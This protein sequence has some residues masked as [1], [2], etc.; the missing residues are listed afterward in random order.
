MVHNNKN[1]QLGN[2][3][4][5]YLIMYIIQLLRPAGLA[6]TSTYYALLI[7]YTNYRAWQ[8]DTIELKSSTE[9]MVDVC[10]GNSKGK[11]E[12]RKE[13][14]K[15]GDRQAGDGMNEVVNKFS[16]ITRRHL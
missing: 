7:D 8:S 12:G 9:K 1:H 13:A 5:D 3:C 15:E 11:K 6:A 14:R 4:H 2:Q 10:L 16:Q